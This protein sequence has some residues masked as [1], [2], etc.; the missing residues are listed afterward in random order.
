MT[1]RREVRDGTPVYHFD[2]RLQTADETVFFD[3]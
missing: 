1:T 2:I 3:L